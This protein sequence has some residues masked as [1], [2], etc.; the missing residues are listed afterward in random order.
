MGGTLAF[1]ML[2][3][4]LSVLFFVLTSYS[5][6]G[7]A[8]LG[9]GFLVG[10][11]FSTGAA[12]PNKEQMEQNKMVVDGMQKELKKAKDVLATLNGDWKTNEGSVETEA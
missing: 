6:V 2:C 5:G 1:G 4:I 3:I 9:I 8:L 10:A 12:M 11:L 7:C